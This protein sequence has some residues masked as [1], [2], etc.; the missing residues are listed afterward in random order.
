MHDRIETGA[1]NHQL[2]SET[3]FEYCAFRG[4]HPVDKQD[5]CPL[6]PY[7]LE[8]P[9]HTCLPTWWWRFGEG[10]E[11]LIDGFRLYSEWTVP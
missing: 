11:V 5:A 2:K 10:G 4:V 3:F 8:Q 9:L 1:H 7:I 6:P